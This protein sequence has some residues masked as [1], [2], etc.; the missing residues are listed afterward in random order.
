MVDRFDAFR[1]C[2]IH[3]TAARCLWVAL[4]C[5]RGNF[6]RCY[7]LQ[8][9]C[10][11]LRRRISWAAH[12]YSLVRCLLFHRV[13][14]KMTDS[15]VFNISATY[16]RTVRRRRIL[17]G[18]SRS[19]KCQHPQAKLI[20]GHSRR[21]GGTPLRL[22]LSLPRRKTRSPKPKNNRRQRWT[23]GFGERHSVEP[24]PDTRRAARTRVFLVLLSNCLWQ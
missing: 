8:R 12:R 5:L 16:H 24:F 6:L 11:C 3:N 13:T 22:L 21:T 1:S 18:R 19:S 14:T 7:L 9:R 15:L 17:R 2:S 23:R 4:K 20:H 10:R